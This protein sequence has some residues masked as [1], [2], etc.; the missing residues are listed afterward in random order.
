LGVKRN[1]DTWIMNKNVNEDNVIRDIQIVNIEEENEIKNGRTKRK[2]IDRLLGIKSD[3]IFNKPY[4]S[5]L[6]SYMTKDEY[7]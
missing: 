1:G 7:E 5:R 2:L 3:I 6:S 4:S